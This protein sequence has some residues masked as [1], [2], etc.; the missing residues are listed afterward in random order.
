MSGA[1]GT[2][3]SSRPVSV[4]SPPGWGQEEKRRAIR[5]KSRKAGM[6]HG[7]FI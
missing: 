2:A 3:G 5:E 4:C 6:N 1:A 7:V